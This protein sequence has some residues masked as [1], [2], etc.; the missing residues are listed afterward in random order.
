M[1]INKVHGDERGEIYTIT[2]EEMSTPEITLLFTK[3]GFA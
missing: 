2:G 3:K 1:E